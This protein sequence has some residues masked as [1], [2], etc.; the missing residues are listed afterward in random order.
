MIEGVFLSFSENAVLDCTNRRK[1]ILDHLRAERADHPKGSSEA[2]F[3]ESAFAPCHARKVDKCPAVD[4]F[5]IN[6]LVLKVVCL[7]DT[8][9]HDPFAA[10]ETAGGNDARNAQSHSER[11]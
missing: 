2:I 10:Q 5:P 1:I 11:G 4:S 8:P 3:Q 7:S 6:L 9:S